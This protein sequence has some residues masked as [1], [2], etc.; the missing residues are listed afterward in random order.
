MAAITT[1]LLVPATL[2]FATI[3]LWATGRLPEYLTALIFFAAATVTTTVPA[4]TIFS[5]FASAAL[6]RKSVV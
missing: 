4:A 2:V 5:G 1:D 3:A 6:D